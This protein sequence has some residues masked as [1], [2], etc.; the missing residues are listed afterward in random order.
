[1]N[2]NKPANFKKFNWFISI[3]LKPAKSKYQFIIA[4]FI[5]NSLT[6]NSQ[7]DNNSIF[8][9][10]I[11]IIYSNKK[12]SVE[13]QLKA[14]IQLQVIRNNC[15]LKNDSGMVYLLQKIGVLFSKQGEYLK[16]IDYTI[17]SI[18]KAKEDIKL[19]Y[20]NA[21]IL[22]DNYYNLY[23][24]YSLT[25]QLQKKY[26][27]IDS[28]IYYAFDQN[29]KYDLLIDP[30][31]DKSDYLFNKGAYDQ[32]SKN[33]KLGQD[34]IQ[35]YY[36]GTDSIQYI[37]IFVTRQAN[38]L[39]ISKNLLAAK[40]LLEKK[41]Q[42]FEVLKKSKEAGS[43]YILLGLIH[44]ELS[45]YKESLAYFKKGFKASL[46]TKF[47]EG[48]AL[49]LGHMG[50]LN[51]KYFNDPAT[52]L[53]NCIKAFK[54]CNTSDSLFTFI[55][56][57]NIYVLKNKY[58]SA[59]YFFQQAYDI[60]QVGMNETL[61]L[62]NTFQFPG[63]NQ[64]Q[65]LSDLTTSKGDAFLQQFY[66]TKNK[67]Y[68]NKA[69][70][71]YKKNDL[72]LAKIKNEQQ[73]Q[74]SAN[75]VWRGTARTLYEHAIEA[76]YN[77][78]N[79]E[80]A[81]YFF[82]KSR[83]ILLND[84]INEQQFM[85][86]TEVAQQANLKQQIIDLE[87]NISGIPVLSDEYLLNQNKLNSCYEAL[88]LSINKLKNKNSFYY[89]NYL[90]QTSITLQQ[91]KNN[92]LK[93]S[94]SLVEVFTGDS[95]VYV[96]CI[97]NNKQSLI[98]IDPVL[99]DS[100]IKRY[101]YLLNN[102]GYL[103]KNFNDF[104]KIS[105]RLYILLFGTNADLKT[106]LII[107][108][109]GK[110]FP[111]EALVTNE[112]EQQPEYLLTKVA[113]SYTYSVKYLTN[114]FSS[115]INSNILGFAPVAFSRH[116]LP[117]L[118]G[119]SFSL[120]AI[121]NYF[122]T[123]KNYIQETATKNNFLQSFPNYSIIQ[124]YTHAAVTDGNSDPIIYFSDSSLLL[125]ELLTD[126]KPSTQLVVL[127]ACETA[128]GKFY[129]GEGIFSFNRGFAA[130][131]IPAAVSNL[132]PVDNLS[133]YKITEL[134][135]KYLGEGLPADIALQKA[136]IN[137]INLSAFTAKTLPYYWA[138]TIL[139]GKAISFPKQQNLLWKYL[140]LALLCVFLIGYFIRRAYLKP[141]KLKVS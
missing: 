112:N 78:N 103:N 13:Q 84:Q 81:L 36:H 115:V 25:N 63:F 126:R 105:H 130:L 108:P 57:A 50:M 128:E 71:V 43:F 2:T 99:Y 51:A 137:F 15:R 14:L 73:L 94:K 39:Y 44:R 140:S 65:N 4:L 97:G 101:N 127:S 40:Q 98:K 67:I 134:F 116:N 120:T 95:A 35:K 100:V 68:L 38:A 79:I 89:Q 138:G 3:I 24:Y 119:S 23:Y 33:A 17:A 11:S 72:F 60:I 109:D 54:Y 83:S 61:L 21:L 49:T 117:T 136:K 107:S 74:F 122:V 1:M 5:I 125:S 18:S 124:L 129:Q 132:W 56:I 9:K 70:E 52:G 30:L 77:N 37:V 64:L 69:L 46:V 141:L 55:Q 114:K 12:L 87:K 76:C 86:D 85:K 22:I 58:D 135:Y 41:V 16:A 80:A 28:C 10:N 26:S 32:C 92:I 7:C 82:E 48:C 66:F 27:S 102:A 91:L 131:G 88:A 62:K 42:E 6:A 34:I 47:K 45:N 133:T 104:V 110:G 121:N 139:T 113:T 53:K 111:F 90:D 8:I 59:Q 106:N 31:N 20:Y 96:L 123:G 93:E 19:K 75:L 118:Y 29:N